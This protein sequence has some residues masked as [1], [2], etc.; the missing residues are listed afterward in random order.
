MSQQQDPLSIDSVIA[1]NPQ[2]FFRRQNLLAG[3]NWF[4]FLQAILSFVYWVAGWFS[5]SVVVFLRKDFGERYL[6]WLNLFAAYS[7]VWLFAGINAF[8]WVFSQADDSS[9]N[10]SGTM[11]TVYGL[12]ILTS[13]YHRFAI[14]L[15]LR[16]GELWHS[17]YEG[18][19]FLLPL[20]E[21][22]V[23]RLFRSLEDTVF[24]QYMAPRA[25]AEVV[26]KW[27]EP[28]FLLLLGLI[29]SPIDTATSGWLIISSIA[30]W[31]REQVE[32]FMVRQFVLDQVDSLIQGQFMQAAL[33]G[34]TPEESRGFTMSPSAVKLLNAAA[35]E[36]A[37]RRYLQPEVSEAYGLLSPAEQDLLD[38]MPKA[39]PMPMP[40]ERKEEEMYAQ[41]PDEP[42]I[43][44]LDRLSDDEK[45]LLDG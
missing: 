16:R 43:P 31:V 44:L 34:A 7:V 42:E 4:L 20:T 8:L 40:R 10:F 9:V 24:G 18:T 39:R 12:F 21:R 13:F 19:S 3:A 45:A 37:A 30:F 35:E 26:H 25:S 29:M 23:A 11:F 6:S 5:M 14:W 27:V 15:R 41:P 17:F 2:G 36:P 22:L 32:Y 33:N 28:V 1:P 38:A